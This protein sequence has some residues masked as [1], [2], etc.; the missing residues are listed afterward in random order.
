MRSFQIIKYTPEFKD[1]WDKVVQASKNGNFLHFRGYMDYH[2][3]RFND[4]SIL[5]SSEG[6]LVAVFPCNQVN[7]SII[8][9][10]GLT[11]G[12]LLYGNSLHAAEILEIFSS[13]NHY[14][15]AFGCEKVLYKA[16]PHV[17]HKY[18]AEEDLYALFRLDAKLV[19]RDISSVI[20]LSTRP[21]LSDSRKNT[22]R[23]AQKAGVV[24][25]ELTDLSSFHNLL[26]SVLA[27]FNC[28][29]VH[30]DA[31][32][33]L[34]HR[35]FPKN[36]RLFGALLSGKLLA[37]ALIYDFGHIVHSQYLASSDEGRTLGAL[38]YVLI[39]LIDVVF[40]DKKYFSFGVSTEE[41]GRVLNEGLIRQ[42]E[43]FG[44]RGVVHDFYEWT[45]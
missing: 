15:K 24:F 41:Q 25:E 10:G 14:F 22:A 3:E 8:S 29:P 9:H 32:L 30:T 20:E 31:E 33:Q 45:L 4:E 44:G 34:L 5:I 27:K 13:I 1:D 2:R 19:R 28:S 26:S 16:V 17:F 21:K 7:T 11:Y 12:G 42:K 23:K 37:A 36:I 35:S 38:D 43:G 6:K 18:P 40:S 39:Q